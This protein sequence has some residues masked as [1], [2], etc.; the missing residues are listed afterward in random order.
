VD[1]SVKSRRGRGEGGEEGDKRGRRVFKR[2]A[3]CGFGLWGVGVQVGSV[4]D[5]SSRLIQIL[6]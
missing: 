5:S 3:A 2:S 4:T 1:A 6:F